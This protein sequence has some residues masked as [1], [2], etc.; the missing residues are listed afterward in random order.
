MKK[1][2]SDSSFLSQNRDD[3][4]DSDEEMRTIQQLNEE[5]QRVK[6]PIENKDR[7]KK[8]KKEIY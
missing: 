4:I 3:N 1:D 2:G 6:K 7:T 8:K 5:V